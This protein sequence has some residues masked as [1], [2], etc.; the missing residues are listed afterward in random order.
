MNLIQSKYQ[1]V[2]ALE[3]L[4]GGRPENQDFMG[5]ADTPLGF[6]MVLCEVDQVGVRRPMS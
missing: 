6:A 2:G 4:Q 3:S 1:I 5:F